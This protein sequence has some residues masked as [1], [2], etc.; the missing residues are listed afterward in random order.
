ML[1][2]CWVAPW[3]RPHLLHRMIVKYQGDKLLL[4]SRTRHK[5]TQLAYDSTTRPTS[6]RSSQ[7]WDQWRKS[8]GAGRSDFQVKLLAQPRSE[9]RRHL[10]PTIWRPLSALPSLADQLIPPPLPRPLRWLPGCV[11]RVGYRRE[12][13]GRQTDVDKSLCG[14]TTWNGS[15]VLTYLSDSL[16]VGLFIGL[17]PS[18][19]VDHLK[20]LVRYDLLLCWLEQSWLKSRIGQRQID[21]GGGKLVV[22][23]S[24]V[25]VHQFTDCVI[26]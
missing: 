16:V 23:L 12:R 24:A 4:Q 15:I 1:S 17:L 5:S 6:H 7:N 9:W 11:S 21:D 25:S 3:Y 10:S 13:Q 22:L 26:H 14:R 20:R 19:K 8:K 18:K 2:A